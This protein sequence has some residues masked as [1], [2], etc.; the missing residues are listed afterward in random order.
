[1]GL[2]QLQQ[3]RFEAAADPSALLSWNAQSRRI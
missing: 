3:G 1:M 2:Q